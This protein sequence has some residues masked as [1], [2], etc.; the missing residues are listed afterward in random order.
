MSDADPRS[1][2]EPA[3]ATVSPPIVTAGWG[4]IP[5][6]PFRGERDPLRDADPQTEGGGEEA[7][8]DVV[9]RVLEARERGGPLHVKV[10]RPAAERDERSDDSPQEWG[11][12]EVDRA[13]LLP[14]DRGAV[15]VGDARLER[16]ADELETEREGRRER[17][18]DP[19]HG[20]GSGAEPIRAREDG[21][22]RVEGE[23]LDPAMRGRAGER[24]LGR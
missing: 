22:A 15:G 19:E 11:P 1:D 2:G 13:E 8:P 10:V 18:P 24:L 16:G 9:A 17:D 7:C 5:G 21:D 20:G 4:A 3:L 6:A 14:D 12:S 23:V